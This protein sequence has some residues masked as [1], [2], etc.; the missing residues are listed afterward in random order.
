MRYLKDLKEIY[1]LVGIILPNIINN[2]FEINY[3]I[4]SISL[5]II[6]SIIYYLIIRKNKKSEIPEFIKIINSLENVNNYND[7]Q[8]K[9][10]SNLEKLCKRNGSN[11]LL[12]ELIDFHNE[13]NKDHSFNFQKYSTPENYQKLSKINEDLE[14]YKKIIIEYKNKIRD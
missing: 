3:P 4:T 2:T 8:S 11:T 1:W 9:F 14:K 12:V 10:N 7:C 13:I 6:F 5:S